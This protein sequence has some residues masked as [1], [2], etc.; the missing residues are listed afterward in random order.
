MT[1][2][3]AQAKLKDQYA[4]QNAHI[5]ENYHRQTVSIKNDIYNKIIS[6]YGEDIKMNGYIIGFILKDLEEEKPAAKTAL[7]P[8]E[9]LPFPEV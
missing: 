2:K 6:K 7:E 4:R 1:G 9:D 3:E 5:K 8:A